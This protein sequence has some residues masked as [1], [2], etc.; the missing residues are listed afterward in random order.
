MTPKQT[1]GHIGG[2]T[3]GDSKR[4][5]M[6]GIKPGR[7]S[8]GRS[9]SLSVGYKIKQDAFHDVLVACK[10]FL[11]DR[12]GLSGYELYNQDNEWKF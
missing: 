8:A 1:N 3:C 5:N 11:T 10:G 2:R 12:T 4:R 7:G 9:D 6:K